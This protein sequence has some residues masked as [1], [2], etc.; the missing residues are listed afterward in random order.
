LSYGPRIDYPAITPRH[1]F[2]F[3]TYYRFFVNLYLLKA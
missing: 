1:E 2:G 3:Y